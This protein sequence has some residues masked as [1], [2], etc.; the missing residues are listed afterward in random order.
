MVGCIS[1]ANQLMKVNTAYIN[2]TNVPP[3][4]YSKIRKERPRCVAEA[5]LKAG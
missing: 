1:T 2:P 5:R 3:T 4:D